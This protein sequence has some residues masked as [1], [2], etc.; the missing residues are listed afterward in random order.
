ML[1]PSTS[2]RA[3]PEHAVAGGWAGRR[4]PEVKRLKQVLALQEHRIRPGF[5]IY[6][7]NAKRYYMMSCGMKIGLNVH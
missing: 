4:A 2:L 1:K 3:L 6:V 5:D 7:V